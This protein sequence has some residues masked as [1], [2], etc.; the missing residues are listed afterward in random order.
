MLGNK[1]SQVVPLLLVVLIGTPGRVRSSDENSPNGV[2]TEFVEQD[3][4]GARATP[5]GARSMS[6]LLTGASRIAPLS[7][8]SLAS[9]D[10]VKT[11]ETSAPVVDGSRAQVAL[12]YAVIGTVD[13][14]LS[15]KTPHGGPILMRQNVTLGRAGDGRWAITPETVPS[16]AI[17]LNDAVALLKSWSTISTA[18]QQKTLDRTLGVLEQLRRKPAASRR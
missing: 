14:T 18:P 4:G 2:V 8:N 16:P 6:R 5:D 10:I 9:L 15:L 12:E 11:Y 7:P 3:L 1:M 17:R 13:K